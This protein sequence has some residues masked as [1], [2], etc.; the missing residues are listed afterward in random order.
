LAMFLEVLSCK[1]AW[2]SHWPL[3]INL[4]FSSFSSQGLWE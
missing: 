1:H 3:A 2:L 4:T